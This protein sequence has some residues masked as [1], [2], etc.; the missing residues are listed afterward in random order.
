MAFI[1]TGTAS[2]T[3]GSSTDIASG[4]R[5]RIEEQRQQQLEQEQAKAKAENDQARLTALQQQYQQNIQKQAEFEK[6]FQRQYDSLIREKDKYADW[7]SSLPKQSWTPE[8]RR[9]AEAEKNVFFQKNLAE[10][11]KLLETRTTLSSNVNITSSQIDKIIDTYYSGSEGSTIKSE[12]KTGGAYVSSIINYETQV[13][14]I[15]SSNQTYAS[16]VAKA[17]GGTAS[18]SMIKLGTTY[19]NV[20]APTVQNMLKPQP[21]L[22]GN[23]IAGLPISQGLADKINKEMGGQVEL[24][25]SKPIINKPDIKVLSDPF[26]KEY[27]MNESISSQFPLRME[28]VTKGDTAAFMRNIN[29]ESQNIIAG[30]SLALPVAALGGIIYTAKQL[31]TTRDPLGVGSEMLSGLK[32]SFKRDPLATTLSFVSA[33]ALYGK[34]GA[35]R[36]PKVVK[37]SSTIYSG[38]VIMKDLTKGT[39]DITSITK[40]VDQTTISNIKGNVII[41]KIGELEWQSKGIFTETFETF[42]NRPNLQRVGRFINPSF[43]SKVVNTARGSFIIDTTGKSIKISSIE[44]LGETYPKFLG[45]SKSTLFTDQE[46]FN[47]K[48][49]IKSERMIMEEG[50]GQITDVGNIINKPKLN[51]FI[52]KD[53][54][55]NIGI[56]SNTLKTVNKP[57]LSDIINQNVIQETIPNKNLNVVTGKLDV[58]VPDLNS[59]KPDI[60]IKAAEKTGKTNRLPLWFEEPTISEVASGS[61]SLKQVLDTSVKPEQAAK[62]K[63]YVPS[64]MK[65]GS[66]TQNIES[67]VR[68][69]AS[70]SELKMLLNPIEMPKSAVATFSMQ[71]QRNRLKDIVGTRNKLKQKQDQFTMSDLNIALG[72]ELDVDR[73]QGLKELPILIQSSLTSHDIGLKQNTKMMTDIVPIAPQPPIVKIPRRRIRNGSFDFGEDKYMKNI[74]KKR[75]KGKRLYEEETHPIISARRMMKE[76][77]G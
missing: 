16:N 53:I 59:F 21:K 71:D 64:H 14:S 42:K 63:P 48:S 31:I 46:A 69:S 68:A 66:I 50:A 18:G 58:Y 7:Y 17:L 8:A 49:L 43:D 32:T 34:G 39:A 12:Y 40:S 67:S 29:R 57:R 55:E 13:S 52:R 24:W 26:P 54:Y 75:K 65:I 5:R 33:E 4:S 76:L 28:P 19:Y 35:F 77:I 44:S 56:D 70:A 38:D 20:H 47:V 45:S 30:V 3:T 74:I 37:P 60:I 27:K 23:V 1:N 51:S 11:N 22:S 15:R 2:S 25:D 61:Q 73:Q 62:P 72:S 6:T 9:Q 41:N 10:R 36:T